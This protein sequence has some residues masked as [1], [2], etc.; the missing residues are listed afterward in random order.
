MSHPNVRESQ[1]H[2]QQKRPS[3]Y[4]EKGPRSLV[5]QGPRPPFE[6][7]VRLLQSEALKV[8]QAKHHFRCRLQALWAPQ[9]APRNHQ[10]QPA[11]P[12]VAHAYATTLAIINV[13]DAL[14]P[15][16]RPGARSGDFCPACR[17]LAPAQLPRCF[18][19]LPHSPRWI[20]PPGQPP[21]AR[22]VQEEV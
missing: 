9:A 2:W 14:L 13:R 17:L 3:W 20:S 1:A 16:S 11:V 22:W 10:Q 8:L 19:K 21:F 12:D 7:W 6:L 5:A 15:A 4:R 18:P